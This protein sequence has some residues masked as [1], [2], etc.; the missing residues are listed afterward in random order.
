M[1]ILHITEAYG[2]GVFTSV[3][4][5]VEGQIQAG[6]TVVLAVS[7]RS[8]AP[9][10]WRSQLPSTV[11]VISLALSRSI[12][13]V[14][15]LKG[16][17]QLSC[18]IRR[19][20]PDAIH[21]HSS[22][23]GFVG[24]LAACVTGFSSKTFYSPRAFAYLAP[25]LSSTK[26]RLYLTLEKVGQLFG[27]TLVACSND[28]LTEAKKLTKNCVVINNSINLSKLDSYVKNLIKKDTSVIN[29]VTAGRVCEAKRPALFVAVAELLKKRG[30]PVQFT[31][32][33]GGDDF[34]VTDAAVCVG[35]LPRKDSLQLLRE[36]ADIYL[37]T[38]SYEGMPL[39][40]LEA[41]ALS[42]PVV[43]A[44]AIGNRS[45]VSHDVS[46]FVAMP[47]TAEELAV[48]VEKLIADKALRLRMGRQARTWVEAE[49]DTP[50]MLSRYERLYKNNN[51]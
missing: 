36:S 1:K 40:V 13:P 49:F 11:K 19:E 7:P 15:D 32:I 3:N 47:D 31:W 10:D 29:V 9:L 16:L 8:E 25:G 14:S 37:Q 2:G 23:A 20:K 45:A 51:E 28:E 50:L 30:I 17:V 38:S 46:G 6:H 18:L 39:S 5:L 48:Y 26:R 27:G 34:P 33:G 21:L 22:K 44:D 35:W 4:Q 24:R 42:L 41:Q 43:V 12:N